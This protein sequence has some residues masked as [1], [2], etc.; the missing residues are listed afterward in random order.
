MASVYLD[1]TADAI[2]VTLNRLVNHCRVNNTDLMF[3]ADTNAHSSLWN[4][5]D[6]NRRGEALED[7]V[8]QYSLKVS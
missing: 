6:T 1:I 5:A 7:F 8:F 3:C 2:P 4:S